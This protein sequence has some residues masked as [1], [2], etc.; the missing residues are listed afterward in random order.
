MKVTEDSKISQKCSHCNGYG[1]TPSYD[2]LSNQILRVYNE[3]CLGKPREK[4]FILCN[5]ILGE[6]LNECNQKKTTDKQNIKIQVFDKLN[7]FDFIIS[8]YN[9]VLYKNFNSEVDFES[10]N[11]VLKIKKNDKSNKKNLKNERTY[12]KTQ[13][14]DERITTAENK[15]TKF[16]E[17]NNKA[18]KESMKLKRKSYRKKVTDLKGKKSS[19]NI[20]SKHY[21]EKQNQNIEVLKKQAKIEKRQGWWS[22]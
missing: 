13:E 14:I 22:Q 1:S 4:I 10:L 2:F 9:E 6:K 16:N 21:G 17:K 19:K 8:K 18:N 11:K 7:N 5:E 3:I 20:S 12:E 15:I